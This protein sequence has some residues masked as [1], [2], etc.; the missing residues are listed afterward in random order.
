[1]QCFC[2]EL[3][4][5]IQQQ[6]VFIVVPVMYQATALGP[7]DELMNKT[8]KRADLLTGVYIL[9]GRVDRYNKGN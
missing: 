5:A 8:D 4:L 1:M 2:H 6:Q 9:V 7:E 3:S